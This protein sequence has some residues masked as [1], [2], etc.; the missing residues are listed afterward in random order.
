MAKMKQEPD[1]STM[2]LE[3]LRAA[4]APQVLKKW[5]RFIEEIEKPGTEAEAYVRA[6]YSKKGAAASASALLKNPK[7]AALRRGINID[8]YQKQG[9][10]PEWVGNALLEVYQRCMEATPH[11]SWDTE[12]HSWVE[13]GTWVFNAN[14]ALSALKALGESM[15]M[16]KAPEQKGKTDT[17]EVKILV[18][19]DMQ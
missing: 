6:G 9:I 19:E 11:K 13:D 16:F 17:L 10:S 15:G 18:P 14:G 2:S 5:E 12:S 1:W 4:T 7:F 3:E 8:K